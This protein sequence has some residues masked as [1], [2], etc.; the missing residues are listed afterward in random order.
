ML[1]K[2]LKADLSEVLAGVVDLEEAAG[3][4]VALPVEVVLGIAVA[5]ELEA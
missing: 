2:V 3:A 5:F 4:R 1:R